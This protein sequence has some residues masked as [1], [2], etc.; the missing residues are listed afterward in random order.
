MIKKLKSKLPIILILLS[1]I[2]Y[3]LFANMASAQVIGNLDFLKGIVPCGTTY[4][5]QPCTVCHFYKL[6]QNIINFFLYIS[7][8]LVTLMATYIAF[9]FMFSGGSPAKITDAK[10]KLWLLVWGLVWIL[11]SWLVLNTVINFIT[12]I[13]KP[14]PFPLPWNQVQ[15]QIEVSANNTT[16]QTLATSRLDDN[17]PLSAGAPGTWEDAIQ[18]DTPGYQAIDTEHYGLELIDP[19]DPFSQTEVVDPALTQTVSQADINDVDP[20]LVEAIIQAES[21]GNTNATHVDKDG[22]ASY[23]LMQVRPDTARRYDADLAGLTD[24]QIGEMLRDPDYNVEIGTAYLQDLAAKYGGDLNKI[25]A[26]YNGGPGANKASV[27]CPGLL[28]WQCRWDNT[29]HTVPNTGYAVTR[30]YVD[31]VNNYYSQLSQ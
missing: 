30:N 26:G 20:N 28:R 15:C 4:A 9:L 31:K 18:T 2:G 24:A 17:P 21:S 10:S 23:G 27:D 22:Q 25:I 7:A 16:D 12:I 14:G 8:A 5:S 11:G 13:G 3:M 29:T 6:L 19:G 1:A